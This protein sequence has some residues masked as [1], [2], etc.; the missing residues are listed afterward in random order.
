MLRLWNLALLYRSF[1]SLCDKKK[2]YGPGTHIGAAEQM[3]SIVNIGSTASIMGTS[4]SAH[5]TEAKHAVL[6]FTRTW[7]IDFAP[8]GIR[9]NAVLPG[10][11]AAAGLLGCLE[12]GKFVDVVEAMRLQSSLK[13]LGEPRE[14]ADSVIFLL[15]T[16]PLLLL[17]NIFRQME[18]IH[19]PKKIIG[20][21]F[22]GS[23]KRRC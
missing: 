1:P 13:R 20:I 5:Y 12:Q 22:C 7:A 15:M 14:L 16:K 9:C 11:V 3:A 18:V 21:D 2:P 8:Y 19:T 23:E 10:P 17:G 6:G 4:G